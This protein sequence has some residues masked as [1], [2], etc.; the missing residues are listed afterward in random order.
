MTGISSWPSSFVPKVKTAQSSFVDPG[1]PD[2]NV[3]LLTNYTLQGNESVGIIAG[4]HLSSVTFN[5]SDLL[6]WVGL[7]RFQYG[8]VPEPGSLLILLL[9]LTLGSA[10][11]TSEAGS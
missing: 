9:A 11:K 5:N 3:D 8:M 7:D 10:L 4:S 1:M 6:D 2:L